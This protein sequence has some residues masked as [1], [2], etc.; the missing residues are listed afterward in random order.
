MGKEGCS[1]RREDT[2]LALVGQTCHPAAQESSSSGLY[3]LVWRKVQDEHCFT[4]PLFKRRR[5]IARLQIF[6]E[7]VLLILDQH[8][9]WRVWVIRTE[10]IQRFFSAVR[11]SHQEIWLERSPKKRQ[12]LIFENIASVIMHFPLAVMAEAG[13][14]A[15][16]RLCSMVCQGKERHRDLNLSCPFTRCSSELSMSQWTLCFFGGTQSWWGSECCWGCCWWGAE[17]SQGLSVM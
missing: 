11:R 5:L 15:G 12:G 7:S 10:S 13:L 14:S 3:N 1:D 16:K 6:K 17:L 8:P 2:R 9:L 4:A